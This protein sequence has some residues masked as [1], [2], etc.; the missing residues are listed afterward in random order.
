MKRPSR[1]VQYESG[2][3]GHAVTDIM[4]LMYPAL[5]W[6]TEVM[7]DSG[8]SRPMILCEYAYAKGNASGVMDYWQIVDEYLSFEGG[9]Q[10]GL[11]GLNG[12]RLNVPD[13]RL[14]WPGAY[15]TQEPIVPS[16][17]PVPQ[18]T[19]F[20]A[21]AAFPRGSVYTNK[22]FAAFY[23]KRGQP[24]SAPRKCVLNGIKV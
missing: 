3:S 8:E 18:Q 20:A 4:V 15:M 5:E 1:P 7:K 10:M 17:Q 24:A 22:D 23:T 16:I 14:I 12:W 11:G 19:V 21:R 6:I 9:F 13:R 2:S